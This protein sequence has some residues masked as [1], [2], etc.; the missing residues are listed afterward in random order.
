MPPTICLCFHSNLW[1]QPPTTPSSTSPSSSS[2]PSTSI[3]AASCASTAGPT[4]AS[5]PSYVSFDALSGTS[6][7]P[8]IVSLK[9]G[10]MQCSPGSAHSRSQAWTSTESIYD[11]ITAAAH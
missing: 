9:T 1:R 6:S 2:P 4:L 11:I 10:L 8:S 5:S 3:A 7:S